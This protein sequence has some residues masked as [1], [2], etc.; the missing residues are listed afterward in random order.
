M[1]KPKVLIVED[2][3]DWRET[4]KMV[5]SDLNCK[6]LEAANGDAALRLIK[7]MQFDV[8]TLD[9]KLPGRM[10]GIDLLKQAKQIEPNLA[11]VIIVTGHPETETALNAGWLNVFAYLE[12]KP[13]DGDKLKDMVVKAMK[14]EQAFTHPCYKHNIQACLHNFSFQPNTVFVGMPFALNDVY[15]HA[16]KPTIE[17]FN[18]I[19]WR[20]D[21]ARKTLDFGCKICAALQAC[22]FAIMDISKPNSNVGIEIGLAYGYGK[23][24]ILLRNKNASKPPSDLAG[25]EYALY[26]DINSLRKILSEYIE[27]L[28]R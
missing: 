9:L 21:E 25:I 7:R 11:P 17:R 23:K 28:L 1:K 12:K 22:R 2:K 20:A 26:T 19:S 4:I 18:L 14:H 8:I 13:F 15:E 3:P 6:F 24:V 16:I 27:D 10:N 5:L